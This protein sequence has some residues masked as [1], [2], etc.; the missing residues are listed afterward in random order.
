MYT[1]MHSLLLRP[2]TCHH[3]SQTTSRNLSVSRILPKQEANSIRTSKKLN[4]H[5]RSLSNP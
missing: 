3:Q 2:T 5:S 1:V 4:N